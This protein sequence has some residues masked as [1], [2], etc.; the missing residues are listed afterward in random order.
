MNLIAKEDEWSL[1]ST[2]VDVAYIYIIT[3]IFISD[4]FPNVSVKIP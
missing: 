3:S 4:V 1:H 2:E